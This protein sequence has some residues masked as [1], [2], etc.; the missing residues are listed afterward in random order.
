MIFEI[1]KGYISGI[2]FFACKVILKKK[3]DNIKILAT[4]DQ[5][6]F[7]AL[8]WEVAIIIKIFLGLLEACMFAYILALGVSIYY[9]L[10][11]TFPILKLIRT[12]LLNWSPILR[13]SY[14]K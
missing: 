2:S 6:F 1:T 4:V 5:V 3:N 9:I 14:T 12:P 10:G 7:W 11:R 13:Y 8:Q